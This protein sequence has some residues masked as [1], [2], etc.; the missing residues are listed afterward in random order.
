MS[1][2]VLN[3]CGM[4]ALIRAGI[5]RTGWWCWEA[6]LYEQMRS[7][8]LLLVDM[9]TGSAAVRG[10][11]RRRIRCGPSPRTATRVSAIM[12]IRPDGYATWASDE[13]AKP[14]QP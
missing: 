10:P 3:G 4:S 7:G 11:S 6:R 5:C 13:P 1:D 14:Q 8:I 12:L 9:S 2:F